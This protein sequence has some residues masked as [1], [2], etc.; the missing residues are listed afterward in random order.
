LCGEGAP[1]LSEVAQKSG[2]GKSNVSRNN[3][4]L[5]SVGV[6]EGG[7]RKELTDEGRQLAIAI[8]NG[9][10]DEIKERWAEILLDCDDTKA[11]ID[12]LKIQGGIDSTQFSN[13]MASALGVINGN[14]NSTGLNTLEEILK[15]SNLITERDEEIFFNPKVNVNDEK[16]SLNMKP[17]KQKKQ[18]ESD[19]SAEKD[20]SDVNLFQPDLHINMQIHISPET[21]PDQI[22]K[23]FKSMNR[24]LKDFK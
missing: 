22:E 15:V 12:M 4:F 8:G 21:K 13:K 17:K 3:G 19:G 9:L 20:L 2:I 11:I 5:K 18:D 23:I 14:N 1:S 24:Y 7:R 16:Q 6:L 10:E